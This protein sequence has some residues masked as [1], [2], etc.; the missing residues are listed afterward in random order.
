M[1]R[2]DLLGAAMTAVPCG[3]VQAKMSGALEWNHLS[4]NCFQGWAA[5]EKGDLRRT[6]VDLGALLLPSFT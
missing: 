4:L 1:L 3:S 2:D 6:G 5:A